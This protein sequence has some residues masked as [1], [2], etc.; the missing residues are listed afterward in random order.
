MQTTRNWR[1]HCSMYM[2]F[3]AFLMGTHMSMYMKFET[4]LMGTLETCLCTF[5]QVVS[6]Y[7]HLDHPKSPS[8]LILLLV[9]F[10][11]SSFGIPL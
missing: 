6:V 4:F 3:E 10:S 11:R 9:S 2:K 1:L 8:F 7:V 5:I